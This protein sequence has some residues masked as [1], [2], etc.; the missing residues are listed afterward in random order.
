MAN[1]VD[2]WNKLHPVGSKVVVTK[3]N[4]E[5]FETKTRSA[6]RMR[7]TA[8]RDEWIEGVIT[9][10]VATARMCYNVKD[11]GQTIT[12]RDVHSYFIPL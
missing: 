9:D 5:L 10:G 12:V 11:A 3:D 6:F 2:A 7:I 4:G 1:K 8:L